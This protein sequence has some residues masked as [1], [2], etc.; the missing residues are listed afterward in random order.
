MKTFLLKKRGC[1]LDDIQKE[2]SERI[3]SGE[4]VNGKLL[5]KTSKHTHEIITIIY[6]KLDVLAK[7]DKQAS[8]DTECS[9]INTLI[10]NLID[11]MDSAGQSRDAKARN[12]MR[13]FEVPLESFGLY[14]EI[15]KLN[16][17]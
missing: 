10:A 14:C 3:E 17:N 7:E 16:I 5:S 8:F 2:I 6:E 9:I 1:S 11:A 12:L 13:L 15:R 4:A